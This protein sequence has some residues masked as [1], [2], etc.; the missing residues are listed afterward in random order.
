MVAIYTQSQFITYVIFIYQPT[1]EVL[2]SIE[3]G[4]IMD[5]PDIC[6]DEIYDLMCMCWEIE[7]D[8]RPTFFYLRQ[9]LAR[10]FRESRT[11]QPSPLLLRRH[12]PVINGKQNIP[13]PCWVGNFFQNSNAKCNDRED[14]TCWDKAFVRHTTLWFVHFWVAVM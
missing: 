7:P 5:P 9:E 1:S 14:V 4:N 12:A 6:P 13:T 10:S 2:E 11:P 8:Q 3:D